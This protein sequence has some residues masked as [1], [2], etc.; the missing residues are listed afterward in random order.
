MPPPVPQQTIG[1]ARPPLARASA[2]PEPA[3][4]LGLDGW[5]MD[6]LFGR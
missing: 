5:L 2:R 3:S 6:R 4:G 1:G